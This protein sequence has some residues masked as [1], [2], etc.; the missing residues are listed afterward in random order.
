MYDAG[1]RRFHAV[2]PVKGDLMG[3]QTLAQYTYCLNNPIKYVDPLGLYYIKFIQSEMAYYAIPQTTVNTL[4]ISAFSFIPYSG[5]ALYKGIK[6]SRDVIVGGN[7]VGQ[8]KPLLDFVTSASSDAVGRTIKARYP[9]LS[10]GL[11]PAL[12]FLGFF[13][14]VNNTSTIEQVDAIIF[15]LLARIGAEKVK[16]ELRSTPETAIIMLERY[17]DN[18]YEFVLNLD[19][20]FSSKSIKGLTLYSVLKNV[21]KNNSDVNYYTS[22]Y[23]S[24]L[25][26]NMSIP[27]Y[28]RGA[29]DATIRDYKRTQAMLGKELLEDLLLNAKESLDDLAKALKDYMYTPKPSLIK[30]G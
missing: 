19:S 11:N 30:Q 9:K 29:G 7:S 4:A 17:M 18:A 13:V 14:S 23:Y 2:D 21:E 3:P 12:N 8:G 20:I 22:E 10:W 24:L 16:S 26:C 5:N 25:Y 27:S 15:E 6:F 28:L 1:D